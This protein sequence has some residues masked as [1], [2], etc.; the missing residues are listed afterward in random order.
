MREQEDARAARCI[1]TLSLPRVEALLVLH[2]TVG[3]QVTSSSPGLF[4]SDCQRESN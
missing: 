4:V 1:V 2:Q 3:F